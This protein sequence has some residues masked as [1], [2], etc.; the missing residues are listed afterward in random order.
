LKSRIATSSAKKRLPIYRQLFDHLAEQIRSNRMLPG[1]ALPSE[2]ALCKQF[3]ISRVTVRQAIANLADQGLVEKRWGSGTYVRDGSLPLPVKDSQTQAP[4]VSLILANIVGSFMASIVRGVEQE[5]REQG[6]EFSLQLSNSSHAQERLNIEA[7]IEKKVGGVILFPTATDGG[8]NPNCYQYLRLVEAG[9][10]VLF[11]DSY[12]PQLPIGYVVS[13]DRDGMHQLT[14]HMLSLGHKR[15][16]YLHSLSNNTSVTA[17]YE[18]FLNA[19]LGKRVCPDVI[20]RLPKRPPGKNDIDLAEESVRELIRSG[21]PLPTALIGCTSYFA[22]G[23]FR[24]LKEAGL[25]VPEDVALA[26]YERLPEADVLEVPLTVMDVPVE[27]MGREAVRR[28]GDL[29][30]TEGSCAAVRVEIPAKI[31]VAQ[32][33]G[34]LQAGR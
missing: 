12:I 8:S 32:S 3:G 7:A 13:A 25:R 24:A 17:R 21:Q 10:P 30:R 5:V 11:I 34:G 19:M 14:E 22:I 2:Q 33:C 27:E 18:G 20:L 26:G 16:G 4:V 1:Q 28:L 31:H 29:V 15:I 23:A 9:I 6:Y